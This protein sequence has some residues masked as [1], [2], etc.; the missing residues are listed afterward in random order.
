MK[1][2]VNSALGALLTVWASGAA[3]AFWHFE[4]HYLR[5]V[6]R[7]A[8]AVITTHCARLPSP[9]S[10]LPTYQGL[11]RLGDKEPVSVLNFGNPNCYCLRYAE[12]D[13]RRLVQIYQPS[14]VRFITFIAAG[15]KAKD[16][17]E[18]IPPG[19]GIV[20]REQPASS[21]KKISWHGISVFGLR[22][23]RSSSIPMGA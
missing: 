21:T 8:G 20:L 22:R 10:D 1:R 12:G 3:Y 23:Q 2:S 13:V 19:R 5:P 18:A 4:G 6:A 15:N 14:G 9:D 16:V 17:P 7:P 11:V